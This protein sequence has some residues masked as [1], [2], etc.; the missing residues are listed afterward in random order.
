MQVFKFGGASIA[1][2]DR[3]KNVAKIITEKATSPT[4][5]VVS[6]MGK[7]TNALEK[8]NAAYVSK[9]EKINEDFQYI[10]DF[11]YQL[12]DALFESSHQIREVLNDHFVEMEW[13]LEEEPNPNIDYCY[14]Q[15]V[16]MGEILSTKIVFHYLQSEGLSIKWLDVRDMIRTDNQ[17]RSAGVDWDATTK[18]I[19][20]NIGK[21][22]ENLP[23]IITQ[24]FIAGSSENF[25]TTLG[26]EGSDFTA[27][28]F[29]YALDASS[30]TVWKDVPG[31][32]TA[33]PSLFDDAR[34]IPSLSYT[35]ILEMADAGAKVLH[36][37]TMRPIQDKSIPLHVKSFL[38]PDTKGTLIS[39]QGPADYPPLIMCKTQQVYMNLSPSSFDKPLHFDMLFEI[40]KRYN[41]SINHI[42]RSAINI[43]VCFD[44]N[45]QFDALLGE[46]SQ[47]FNCQ[48]QK[49]LT[50]VN[51]RHPNE[52]TILKMIDGK[53]TLLEQKSKQVYKAIFKSL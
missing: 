47:W 19:K 8:L 38:D 7:M 53:E 32:M 16:S 20:H 52:A 5:I 49:G 13:L 43:Y 26:R 48:H 22:I 6:A 27:S 9:S 11:H 37:K 3:I 17:Y 34:F 39:D 23:L 30:V 21:N 28:I 10:K 25:T 42:Q 29:A 24:G 33:D 46:L 36:P 40:F 12:V 45:R 31:I 44:E 35:E 50:L 4:I 2:I 1:N 18:A 15:I 14:D 41:T 51:I